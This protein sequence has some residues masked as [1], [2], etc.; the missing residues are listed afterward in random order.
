VLAVGAV[1]DWSGRRL[2]AFTM[3]TL[4]TGSGGYTHA[5]STPARARIVAEPVAPMSNGVTTV[6]RPIV[7]PVNSVGVATKTLQATTDPGTTPSGNAYRFRIEVDGH[8]ISRFIAA[9]PHDTGST[10]D[11]GDLIELDPVPDLVP[12][13]TAASGTVGY[14]VIDQSLVDGGG[15]S[16]ATRTAAFVAAYATGKP[17]YVPPGTYTVTALAPP[18]T[19]QT[20]GAGEKSIIRYA[21]TGTMCTLSSL[22]RVRFVDLKFVVTNTAGILFT[23]DGCFNGSFTRCVF[24]GSHTTA[25]DSFSGTSGHIG[26]NLINN[27]GDNNLYDCVFLNL[28]VGYKSSAIQNGIFGGKFGT[29]NRGILLT[30]GGGVAVQGH[31]DFVAAQGATPPTAVAIDIDGAT[32][33]VWLD[34]VW[35]EGCTVGVKVGTGTSGPTQFSM[36]NSKVAAVTT[37]MD[38]VAC[39]NPTI[40]GVEFAGDVANS[41]TPDPLVIDATNTPEG[42]AYVDSVIPGKPV[43]TTTPP[44]GWLIHTRASGQSAIKMPN[45]LNFSYGA[46]FNMARSDGTYIPFVQM[47]GGPTL[48]FG[49]PSNN[50]VETLKIRDSSGANA[51]TVDAVPSTVNYA[52]LVPAATGTGPALAARGTDTNVNLT[53]TPKGTGQV[54]SG[55]P[56]FLANVTAPATPTGG[57]VLYVE[58]G[59]LKYKGSSGTVTTLGSA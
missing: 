15:A 1:V 35:I 59:A 27:A 32:G 12:A 47:T 24:Q 21:G 37:C 46:K 16:D 17:V 2:M 50:A 10:V 44:I 8:A 20:I 34:Q 33:Q 13:T 57:G 54:R 51:V 39:R 31:T 48:L 58:S 29:C 11:I 14:A 55:G 3:I 36:T 43:S 25:G 22:Q 56:V 4:D 52:A 45:E 42:V 30:D 5:D 53:L 18:T 41:F 19:S 23:L 7:L 38:F 6:A 40:F 9:V 26:L 49:L 28:A